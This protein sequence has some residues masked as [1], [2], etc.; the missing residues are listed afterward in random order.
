DERTLNEIYLPAFEIAV[1]EAQPW[2][3]MTS[4]NPVNSV[5]I[6]ENRHLL[7]TV[8][9]DQW[10]FKGCVIS[11]W[12][13]INDRVVSLIA[14]T[15]LEMPGSGSLNRGKILAAVENG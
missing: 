2:T 13:A 9:R 7:Q 5:D 15:N 10:G 4:Y 6:T 3:I 12:G 11:D 1:K 14:G 8:L